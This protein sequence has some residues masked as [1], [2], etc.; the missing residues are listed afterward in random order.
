MEPVHQSVGGSVSLP[1]RRVSTLPAIKVRRVK[2]FIEENLSRELGTKTIARVT[3]YSPTHFLRMFRVSTGATPHQ[4]LIGRRV[5]RAQQLL[6]KSPAKLVDIAALCGFSSQAHLATVFRKHVGVTPTAY[7][8]TTRT[9]H[10]PAP[11]PNRAEGL[12]RTGV[13]SWKQDH[14]SHQTLGAL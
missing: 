6:S 7:R 4:Y 14:S 1:V 8:R 5:S 10:S 9:Q 2:E 12:F 13:P 11:T 3:G